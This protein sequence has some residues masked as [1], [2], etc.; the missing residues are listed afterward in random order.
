MKENIKNGILLVLV[1]FFAIFFGTTRGNDEL[2]L[3]IEWPTME[4][5]FSYP[6][7]SSKY[8]GAYRNNASNGIYTLVGKNSDETYRVYFIEAV[9][10]VKN[11]IVQMD[12]VNMVNNKIT[13]SDPT[14]ANSNSKLVIEFG[15]NDFEVSPAQLGLT[16]EKLTGYYLKQ[17]DIGEFSMN[18]FKY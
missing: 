6:V 8:N 18:E 16:N 12:A 14:N 7:Y 9:G 5:E 4:K 15:D 1:V 11:V 2:N 17:K 3:N 10:G 13:F